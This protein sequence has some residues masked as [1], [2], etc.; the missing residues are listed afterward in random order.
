MKSPLN[1]NQEK[2]FGLRLELALSV[3]LTLRI[4]SKFRDMGN[5]LAL[6]IRGSSSADL[7]V[8]LM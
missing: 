5:N 8:H 4:Q 1:H 2:K 7:Y 3:T 6:K